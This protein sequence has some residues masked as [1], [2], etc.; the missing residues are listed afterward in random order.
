M[1]EP[2]R[3]RLGFLGA[4][5]IGLHR[6]AGMAGA[7]IAD[8]VAVADSMPQVAA[9]AAAHVGATHVL[10]SLD[11]LLTLDLDGIVIATP[12]ALHAGQATAVLERGLAVFCQKPLGRTTDEVCG[13][14]DA[15]R[16]SD[17]L[18]A[19]DFCYRFTDGLQKIYGLIRGGELGAVYA[20]DLTF[21]NAYGPDKPWFYN[22]TLSGGG[23]V[24]DLGVHLVDLVLWMMGGRVVNV[25]GRLFSAGVP[26]TASSGTVEDFATLRLDFSDGATAQLACSWRLHAGR[27]ARIDATF[28]GTRGAARWHNVHGSFYDFVTERLDG[29]NTTIISEPPEDWGPRAIVHWGRGLATNASFDPSVERVVD[30]TRILDRVYALPE[31]H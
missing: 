6:M 4:G 20:A 9:A 30:V 5:W 18:L 16:A 8:I 10:T 31:G 24:V 23:C 1:N 14:L 19:V 27:E 28:Y 29:T 17:R 25:S 22:R 11:D 3:P 2:K 21:H 26:W 12:S 15:A 13:V 7:G